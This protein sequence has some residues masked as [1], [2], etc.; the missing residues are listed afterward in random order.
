MVGPSPD[1][2][3]RSAVELIRRHREEMGLSLLDLAAATRIP[4]TYLEALEEGRLHEIP[5]GPYASGYLR[6]VYSH[7]GVQEE[8]LSELDPDPSVVPPQ[9]APLALVRGMALVSVLAL[10]VLLGSALWQ[11]LGF[12]VEAVPPGLEPDQLL[13]VSARRAT[14]LRAVIDGGRV[15]E[16]AL[17]EGEQLELKGI[18]RIEIELEAINHVRLRWND[19]NVVPQGLQDAPRRL[20]FLDDAGGPP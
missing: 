12:E 2:R 7:L 3:P 13:S 19:E 16:H 20:V 4:V 6:A 17:A 11:R 10:A 1:T 14:H 8:M 15:S 18:E 9:G 5:S